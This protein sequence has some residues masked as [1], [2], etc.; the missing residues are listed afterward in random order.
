MEELCTSLGKW[1][2][3]LNMKLENEMSKMWR[4]IPNVYYIQEVKQN[5]F[6]PRHV[7]NNIVCVIADKKIMFKDKKTSDLFGDCKQGHRRP[8]YSR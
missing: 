4:R 1:T 8:L 7:T 2:I 5:L 3:Y 6:A